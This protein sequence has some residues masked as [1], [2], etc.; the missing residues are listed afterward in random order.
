M[1]C[2]ADYFDVPSLKEYALKRFASKIRE[3]WVS[4]RFNDCIR[5][6]F[7]STT[8]SGGESLRNAVVLVAKDHLPAL[9]AKHTFKD[10]L[11]DGGDFAED[12]MDL[13][14]ATTR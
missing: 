10:L 8:K 1:Y 12:L 14:V 2:L 6:V 11:R 4:D 3:L 9:W 13:M 7:D 5:N